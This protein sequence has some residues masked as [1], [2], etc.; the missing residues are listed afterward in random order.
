L[1]QRHRTARR[2]RCCT[3]ANFFFLESFSLVEVIIFVQHVVSVK[4]FEDALKKL[5]EDLEVK[6]GQKDEIIE[7]VRLRKA[8]EPE[9]DEGETGDD[10]EGDDG[11]DPEDVTIGCRKSGE[12]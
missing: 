6:M 9:P 2:S 12:T 8:G 4:R 5:R 10:A 7:M 3:C 11:V 1:S